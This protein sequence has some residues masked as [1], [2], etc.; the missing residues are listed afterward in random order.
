MQ[1]GVLLQ[2]LLADLNWYAELDLDVLLLDYGHWV[3]I[4]AEVCEELL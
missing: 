1:T 3:L 2:E 4:L